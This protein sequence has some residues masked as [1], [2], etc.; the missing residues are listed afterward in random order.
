[1]TRFRLQPTLFFLLAAWLGIIV[2]AA[3]M[4]MSSEIRRAELQF[5][6]VIRVLASDVKHKLD[7][8]EAVLAGFAAFLQAV[9]RSDTESAKRYAASA[10]AAYPHIYMLE[11]ARKVNLSSI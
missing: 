6:E 10:A 3:H 2:F 9:D 1:M 5:D 11:V 4:L 7:T 8:N